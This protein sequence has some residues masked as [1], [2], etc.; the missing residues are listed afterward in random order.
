MNHINIELAKF[1]DFQNDFVPNRNV[2]E[3]KKGNDEFAVSIF[4]TPEGDFVINLNPQGVFVKNKE[5]IMKFDKKAHSV[6][7]STETYFDSIT[8]PNPDE[9]EI[10]INDDCEKKQIFAEQIAPIDLPVEH[11]ENEMFVLFVY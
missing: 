8:I 11:N 9:M 4:D 6:T 3:L 1:F 2:L 5:K 10:E 7:V